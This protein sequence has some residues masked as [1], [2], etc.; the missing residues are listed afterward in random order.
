MARL[1]ADVGSREEA[2][3]RARFADSDDKLVP[4]I[5][6]RRTT[7]AEYRNAALE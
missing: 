5:D 1:P 6:F 7:L 3:I 2:N 4:V